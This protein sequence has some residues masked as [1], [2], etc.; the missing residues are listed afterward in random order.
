MLEA[1]IPKKNGLV[2]ANTSLVKHITFRAPWNRRS[3]ETLIYY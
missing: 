2:R 3:I 1:P